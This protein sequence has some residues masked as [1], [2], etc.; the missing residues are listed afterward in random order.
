MFKL[1]EYLFINKKYKKD[2]LTNDVRTAYGTLTSVIGIICNLILSIV[3]ILAGILASSISLTADGI[4]NL[5]DGAA[6]IT[7]LIGFRLAKTPADG[8]H[9]FGHERIEYICGMFVSLFILVVGVLLGKESIDKIINN[10]KMDLSRFYLLLGILIFSIILKFWMGFVYKNT[11]KKIHSLTIIAASQDSFN[12]CISTFAVLIALII[13]KITSW[14]LDGYLGIA[15]SIFILING[16]KLV[17]ET[18]S[19]LIGEAPNK[20][21]VDQMVKKIKAYPGVLGVHDLAIHSYGPG[22]LFVTI[23]VEVDCKVDILI[24]HEIIDTIERDFLNND[25]IELTIHL[26][27]IDMTDELTNKLREVLDKIVKE[28]NNITFHDF[29]IVKG[30]KSINVLFD[31]VRP[32][33]CKLSNDELVEEIKTEFISKAKKISNVDYHLIIEVDNNYIGEDEK[34]E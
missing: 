26:D 33:D 6:S 28:I 22:K 20:E 14:Q 5:T 16:V 9:P 21:M 18:M 4:N 19:P 7:T 2:A 32:Y 34:N 3:K 31:V 12:D 23:H 29:R 10:E 11:G 17:L 1:L 15:V 24:S 27:P 25:G 30:E 13:A 8:R